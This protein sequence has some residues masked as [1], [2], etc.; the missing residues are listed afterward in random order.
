MR[1][2]IPREVKDGERRVAIIPDGVRA[3]VQAGHSVVVEHDAGVGS[4][5]G[6]DEYRSAGAAIVTDADAVWTCPLIV[7]VKE[8]QRVELPR[9]RAGTTIFGFAQL[10]RDV[11]LLAALL[12]S[13]V[14]IVGFETVRD[15][16][17]ALPLLAPMSRIAGRLAPLIGAQILQTG[18]GGGGTLI[19]G[20]DAVESARVVVIGAGNVGTEAARVAAR[21]GCRVSLLSRGAGRLAVA[22]MALAGEQLV[23]DTTPVGVGTRRIDAAV[24]DADLVIGA[25]LEPG[26]LSP[27]LISR[28][29]VQAMRRGSAIVDVG[30]DHG[31]IAATSR[32]TTLSQPTYVDEGVVHYAVPNMPALVARTAT[33]AL[34]AVTL[35]YVRTLADNGVVAA[36]DGNPGLAAAVMLWDGVIAHAGLA[37]DAAMPLSA[38]PWRSLRQPVA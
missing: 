6:N 27:K 24:A 34:A 30:I 1:I 36:L 2:G 14:R 23:V 12:A 35:P 18:N 25:V 22:A 13:G 8:V 26:T 16:R 17:G 33:R 3:L 28:E 29:A 21:L 5:F 9:L 4:G 37:A 15:S 10:N 31:G 20:V 19:T 11:A 32:M 38:A 7:K